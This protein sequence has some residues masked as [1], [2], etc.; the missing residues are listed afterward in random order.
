MA[1]TSAQEIQS[2]T[3]DLHNVSPLKQNF[4][5]DAILQQKDTISSIRIF[6]P[7]LH[8]QFKASEN[9]R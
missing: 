7:E 4:F 3:G 6:R 9:D 8:G 1:S 5:F 2:V